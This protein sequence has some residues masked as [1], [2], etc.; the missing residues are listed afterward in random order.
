MTIGTFLIAF[1]S[2]S[3][4]ALAQIVLRK[5]MIAS[6]VTSDSSPGALFTILA[7]NAWLWTGIACYGISLCLWLT[8][9]SRTE[10]GAAYP[11]LSIGFVL[12]ALM[13][14]AFLGET[15]SLA[16]AG[17]IALICLGVMMVTWT[18]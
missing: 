13:G 8:V 6:S 5:A 7:T 11:L 2:I 9:L 18:A 4:N 3:L 1:G 16:R 14:F 15:L 10:V 17:G 12:A